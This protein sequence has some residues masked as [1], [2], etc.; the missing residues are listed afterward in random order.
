MR[1][2]RS[3][4]YCVLVLALG[5]LSAQAVSSVPSDPFQGTWFGSFTVTNPNG[6]ISHDTAVVVVE[7]QG[8]QITGTAGPTIDHQMPFKDAKVSGSSL[9]F[10]IDVQGGVAFELHGTA[11]HLEGTAAGNSMKAALDLK[12]APG[13]V[14]H[15]ELT[16]EITDADQ[17]MF[18]AF[19]A[20]DFDRYSTFL[21]S[22]LEFYHDHVGKQDYASH[23]L[24]MHQRCTEGITLRRELVPGTLLVN[25]APG[26]GAIEA[27][28]HK[29]YSKQPDGSEHLDATAEFTNVWSKASG[30]WKLARAVSFDHH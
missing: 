4:L 5:K 16:K 10:S 25:A 23:L 30:S 19:S 28:T 2:L 26:F 6:T 3:V 14:P 12:P 27:G 13:L 20:C 29:F 7:R 17:Q 9:Q 22:D 24:A 18:A 1:H 15:D 8:G 21:A 11:D